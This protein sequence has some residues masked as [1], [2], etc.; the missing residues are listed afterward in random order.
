VLGLGTLTPAEVEGARDAARDAV[1]EAVRA[2]MAAPDADPQALL[3]DVAAAVF[4]HPVGSDAA[5]GAA[6]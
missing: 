6:R 1:R 5:T 2:A 4:S 3:A